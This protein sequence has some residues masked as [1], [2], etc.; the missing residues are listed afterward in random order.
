MATDPPRFLRSLLWGV[1]G[2][3]IGA[4]V[5]RWAYD[6]VRPVLPL[7][8]MVLAAALLVRAWLWWRRWRYERW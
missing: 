3:A 5:L 7:L 1:F 4:W 8:V 2:V 6:T